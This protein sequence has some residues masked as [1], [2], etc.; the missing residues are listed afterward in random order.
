M[1]EN[2]CEYVSSRGLLKS[3]D[4]Y[5]STPISSIH[6]LVNYDFSKVKDGSV[7]YICNSALPFFIQFYLEKIPFKI[8]LVTG[9]CD[10][11]C[12]SDLFS[13]HQDFISFIE[14]QK[15]IHWFSQ[16]CIYQH[17]KLSQIPI[18]LDYHTMSNHYPLWGPKLNP[19]EQ[20]CIL[21]NIIKKSGFKPFWER[22]IKCYSN[23]HFSMNTKF[24]SDRKE[25]FST[26]PKDLVYYESE[27]KLREESWI[28][29]SQYSFVISPHGNGL[30]CHRTWEA[31]VLG[32]IPIVKT[33]GLDTLYKD[34]PVL[35][36]K[37]WSDVN[38]DLLK[39][40]IQEF[41]NKKFNYERL[42]LSYWVNI[43][44]ETYKP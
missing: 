31:L 27:H 13:S 10:E 44:R 18:G 8:I 34:L 43:I 29:Q 41:Q 3:C 26:I 33:S 12:W 28:K 35:I 16:N 39:N 24:G 5:S 32:C 15:I 23:F 7:I 37:Q 4:I 9:D 36:V 25:A 40:T 19:V 20:E 11:T 42:I 2:N 21:K 17:P 30:D 38:D 6:Q 22:E 14:N 1:N